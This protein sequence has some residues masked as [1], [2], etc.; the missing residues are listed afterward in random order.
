MP[1]REVLVDCDAGRRR[2]CSTFC[3]RLLVRLTSEELE[4][5]S[6]PGVEP[7]MSSVPKNP[8]GLCIHLDET[9]HRCRIWSDRPRVCR[10]YDCAKD[11]LLPVVLKYGFHSLVQLVTLA[12]RLG[13]R[14]ERPR[15]PKR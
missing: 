2:G 6:I 7:G 1:A 3:C 9:T 10:G 11:E 14:E 15:E 4:K 12:S 13:S 8:D 5:R